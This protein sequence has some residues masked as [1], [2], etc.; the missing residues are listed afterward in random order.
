M[1]RAILLGCSLALLACGGT[2]SAPPP[3]TRPAEPRP[4]LDL[5]LAEL[6]RDLE[7]TVLENYQQLT[8]GNLEAWADGVADDQAV[9]LFGVTPRDVR[10]DADAAALREERRLYWRRNPR[11]LSKNLEVHVSS[12]GSVGWVFDEISYRVTYLGREASIPIRSSAVYVRDVDRWLLASEHLSYPVALT[13]VA[14]LA[15]AGELA[16][17]RRFATDFRGARR[18]A[19]SLV[20]S[21]GRL[22][23]GAA[24]AASAIADRALLVLPGADQELRGEAILEMPLAH[25]FGRRATVGIRDY[26]LAVSRSERVA[27]LAANLVVTVREGGES[28]EL[29]LRGTYVFERA[30]S[31]D[32]RLRHGHVSAPLLERQVSRRVF[33]PPT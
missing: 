3:P 7:A 8:L 32:W 23:N 6:A 1:S 12:D 5:G 19:A 30:A 26:R 29:G 20:S 33:G 9:S 10:L 16:M 14:S 4:E 24:G 27:W 17:P 11:Y 21:V 31:G 2:K 28:V 15:L 25:A 22:H 13:E 18:L